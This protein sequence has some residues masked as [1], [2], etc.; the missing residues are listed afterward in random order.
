MYAKVIAIDPSF[1]RSGMAVVTKDKLLPS[2]FTGKK[3]EMFKRG[4]QNIFLFDIQGQFDRNFPELQI[5]ISDI[6]VQYQEIFSSF[7]RIDNIVMEMPPPNC[8]MSPA[9]FALDTALVSILKRYT[10][11]FYF[12][13]PNAINSYFG[14]R[15]V[16]KSAIVQRFRQDFL[17]IRINHDRVSAFYLYEIVRLKMKDRKSVRPV[18]ISWN[19]KGIKRIK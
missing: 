2:I 12:L 1:K 4:E 15:T 11:Q 13:S 18:V 6:V 16:K 3:V 9:L 14:A 7:S 10:N 5:V 8:Q 19:K 17:D